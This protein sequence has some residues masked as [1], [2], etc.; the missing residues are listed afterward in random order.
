MSTET[1][2]RPPRTMM[3]VFTSLPE[4]TMVQ[5]IENN[6]VMSPAPKDR[7]Q[8]L[9]DAIYPELS[10]FVKRKKLGL[11][12]VAP[13]DVFFDNENVYQPDII[14]ISNDK[15]HLIQEDGMHGA[16]SLV[17]EILSPSTARF[18]LTEKKEVYARFG[19]TEYWIVDPADNSTTG[20]Y[21]VHD[22]YYQFFKGTG[23]I[24]SK[25]LEWR[26]EF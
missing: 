22:E 20:F 3:E 26:V 7:H 12:R 8:L 4:G 5:L 14:V 13:Y 2:I 21:L 9:V 25:L 23:L 11:T 18:D 19:V 15:K 16:P 17:I 10:I 6:L 1:N 24:E